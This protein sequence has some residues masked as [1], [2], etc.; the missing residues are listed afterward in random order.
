MKELI[1]NYVKEELKKLRYLGDTIYLENVNPTLLEDVIGD[2]EE[3][4]ELNGYDCDY[5]AKSGDYSIFGC[6]SNGTAKIRLAKGEIKP[7]KTD[8]AKVQSVNENSNVKEDGTPIANILDNSANWATFY[9]SFGYGHKHYGYYQP[10][11]AENKSK[12]HKK[13]VEVYGTEW[14]F[15]YTEREW[16]DANPNSMY[17]PLELLYAI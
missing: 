9:F 17:K 3:P 7:V 10:I 4:Y 11:K 13:M 1:K 8:S 16:L 5:W 12:A 6:M 2:F 14:A 15:I